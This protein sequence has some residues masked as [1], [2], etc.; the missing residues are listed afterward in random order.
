M[1]HLNY[2]KSAKLA[3][4]ALLLASSLSVV[5]QPGPGGPG[6]PPGRGGRG[7][8]F[9]PQLPEEQ[10]AL[11]QKIGQ[12]LE[13][14]NEAVNVASSNLVAVSFSTPKDDGKIKSANA[15]LSKARETWAMKASKL[16]AETQASDTKLSDDALAMLV[17]SAS[18]MGG[19]GRGFGGPP[20]MR[21][22]GPGGQRGPG[23][24]GGRGGSSGQR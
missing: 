7:G 10:M 16:V 2:W 1:K 19:R 17:R 13:A 4:A 8:G 9:G 18:G 24:P 12:A 22:G 6:G 14:E 5:A 15:A 23:G 3:A 21:P 20:G 11:V